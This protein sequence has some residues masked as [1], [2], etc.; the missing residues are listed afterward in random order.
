MI[1]NFAGQWKSEWKKR[2]A[3]FDK[4][5]GKAETK[6]KKSSWSFKFCGH[7]RKN[8]QQQ[9]SAILMVWGELDDAL[10]AIGKAPN[11]KRLDAIKAFGDKISSAERMGK[12]HVVALQRI[13]NTTSPKKEIT[14]VE[15]TLKQRD[16]DRIYGILS[17]DVDALISV[18]KARHMDVKK[19]TNAQGVA[20]MA[21]VMA[22]LKD[23]KVR[24]APLMSN[25]KKAQAWIAKIERKPEVEMFNNGAMDVCRDVVASTVPMREIPQTSSKDVRVIDTAWKTLWKWDQGKKM[26]DG[27]RFEIVIIETSNIKK[28]VRLLESRTKTLKVPV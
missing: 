17:K 25:I 11:E 18:A 7:M 21:S 28:A 9:D 14:K 15:L 26:D 20:G 13:A 6:T 22:A 27:N 8:K 23:M 19:S 12:G 2:L 4:E 5:I 1:T 24:K 3:Y 16:L 10:A